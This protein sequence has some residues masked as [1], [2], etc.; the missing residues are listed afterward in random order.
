MARTTRTIVVFLALVFSAPQVWAQQ[1]DPAVTQALQAMAAAQQTQAAAMQQLAQHLAQAAPAPAAQP[2]TV[3]TA[4]RSLMKCASDDA[5]CIARYAAERAD[6]AV[7]AA[8]SMAGGVADL[9]KRVKTIEVR[10]GRVVHV[11]AQPANSAAQIRRA[12]T[13]AAAAAPT[14][15]GVAAHVPVPGTPAP[16]PAKKDNAVVIRFS[17]ETP[18]TED[19]ALV[20]QRKSEGYTLESVVWLPPEADQTTREV[21]LRNDAV[22]AKRDAAIDQAAGFSV[23]GR[24]ATDAEARDAAR[25]PTGTMAYAVMRAPKTAATTQ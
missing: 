19:V 16:T 8:T 9:E 21:A 24:V 15:G 6:W 4:P 18:R 25:L 3:Q 11:P 14:N 22:W 7:D 13:A 10:L 23:P 12:S 2:A 1:A 17:G 5:L 20:L